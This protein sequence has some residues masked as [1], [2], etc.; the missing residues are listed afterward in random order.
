MTIQELIY[1][2]P[3]KYEQGFT[4]MEVEEL[5]TL[6]PECNMEKFNEALNGNTCMLIDEEVIQYH[7]DI[8]KALT[9]GTENRFLNSNEWD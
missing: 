5:L 4:N 9:C 3:T 2:Y 8:E 7:C 1:A 6:Y